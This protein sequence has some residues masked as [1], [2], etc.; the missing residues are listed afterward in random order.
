MKLFVYV[1]TFITVLIFLFNINSNSIFA[2]CAPGEILRTCNLNSFQV[3]QES[4]GN[5]GCPSGF[6]PSDPSCGEGQDCCANYLSGSFPNL[7]CSPDYYCC[8]PETTPTT[9][10][11]NCE[12]YGPGW[13]CI[14]TSTSY[15]NSIGGVYISCQSGP[16]TGSCCAPP[17]TPTPTGGLNPCILVGGRCVETEDDCAWNELEISQECP[18]SSPICCGPIDPGGIGDCSSLD[19]AICRDQCGENESAW[20][21]MNNC[22]ESG[23]ECCLLN[24]HAYSELEIW[25]DESGGRTAAYTGK[26]YTAI[27]CIPITGDGTD[28]VSFILRWGIGIAGGIAL[29]LIVFGAIQ[30]ITAGG[31]PQKVQAGKELISSALAG[32]LFLL[33]S[34]Y[35]LEF[36]GI[37]ILNIF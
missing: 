6:R 34:V 13:E 11:V 1:T 21:S 33:L 14:S 19:D 29:L 2:Q 36:I 8:V 15:C 35:L 32:F 27:G 16:N 4:G 3:C 5:V 7:S 25:C 24:P 30:I 37:E 23:Q 17:P 28:F 31:N 22:M 26:L 20:I 10:P 12:S 9:A 18:T